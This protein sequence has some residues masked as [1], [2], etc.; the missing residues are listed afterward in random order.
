[1]EK[2]EAKVIGQ[3]GNVFTT[4]AICLT[5]LKK[6]KQNEQAKEL[7]KRVLEAASYEKALQIMQEYCEFC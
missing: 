1:M 6:A 7:Q 5:A 4:L 2:P 3:D